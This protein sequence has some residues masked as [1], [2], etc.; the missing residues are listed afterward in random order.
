VPE[1]PQ[2]QS[3]GSG[4]TAIQA[5][6][7]V[8]ITS[9]GLSYGEVRDVALD[10]FRANFYQLAGVAAETAAARAQEVTE[11]FLSKLE[12]E[13]PSGI[14]KANDPDFQYSLLTVQREYARCGDKELEALLVDL[15]VDRSKQDGRNILQIVLN[16]SLTTA[17]K[18]TGSQL[19]ALAIIFLL[20][21]TQNFGVGNHAS[22]GA[23]LDKHVS[24][25]IAA[26]ASSDASYQHMEFTGCGS[27]GML[28]ASLESVLGQVY[29]GLFQNGFDASEISSRNISLGHDTRF[30]IPCFNDPT[31]LQVRANSKEILTKN[32]DAFGVAEADRAQVVQLFDATKMSDAQIRD[33]C[34]QIRP[35]MAELFERWT[36]SP[37]KQFTLTSVGMAIGHANIKRLVGEFS[38]L[39]IWIN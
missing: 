34:V 26:S 9:V 14:G 17:P 12:K 25:F 24:P 30:F 15:L 36:K 38:D 11:D 27:I 13:N 10:V 37:M 33:K 5:G 3:V 22:F 7:A 35:Y 6:G 29:Q 2:S 1:K 18:L 16:E 31:K 21:Y 28:T 20:R 23:Y 32:F 39:S 4:G 8:S 19:A